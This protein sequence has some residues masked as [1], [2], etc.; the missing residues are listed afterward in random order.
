MYFSRIETLAR[1]EAALDS[2][3]RFML[4]DLIEQRRN[5]WRPRKEVSGVG[6]ANGPGMMGWSVE[7]N[8]ILRKLCCRQ[9]CSAAVAV[10]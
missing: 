3:H 7:G 10:A 5:R 6:G 9:L 2:R 8:G 1:N 4:I